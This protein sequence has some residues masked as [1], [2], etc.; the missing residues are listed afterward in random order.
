[1]LTVGGEGYLREETNKGEALRGEAQPIRILW[2]WL[3]SGWAHSGRG[4][5]RI[6]HE[7]VALNH[8]KPDERIPDQNAHTCHQNR[9]KTSSKLPSRGNTF[10]ARVKCC[11]RKFYG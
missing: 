5:H 8:T 10:S 3:E 6:V 4:Q 7:A 1:M 2:A 11:Q 9:T